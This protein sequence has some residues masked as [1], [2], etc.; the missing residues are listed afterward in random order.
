MSIENTIKNMSL[1]ERA[2]Q[3]VMSSFTGRTSIPE[4]TVEL[5]KAGAAGSIL[6]FSGCNVVDALQLRGLT[7]KVQKASLES[8]AGLP[9]FIAIDQEGGQL[10]P[11]TKGVCIGPGNMA[12]AAIRE[13]GADYAYKVGNITGK[14]LKAIGIDVCFAPVVDL[15]FEEGLPG[16]SPRSIASN[17]SR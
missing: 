6:Y 4:E 16:K 10:A 13:N 8:K 7:E 17:K 15:C 14:E 2:G 3:L 1:D 9:Q 11:I 12:L 5:I